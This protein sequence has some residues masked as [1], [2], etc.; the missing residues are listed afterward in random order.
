MIISTLAI[1]KKSNYAGDME[2]PT[3]KEMVTTIMIL[4]ALGLQLM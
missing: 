3:M 4:L 2:Y 1:S